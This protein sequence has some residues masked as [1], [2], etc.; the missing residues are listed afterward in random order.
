MTCPRSSKITLTTGQ[1][2]AVPNTP[3]PTHSMGNVLECT[4]DPLSEIMDDATPTPF[5]TI[6]STT[7]FSESVLWNLQRDFYQ[8]VGERAW[9]E[10]I[11]PHFVSNNAF[12][13]KS[14]A[15]IIL[16]FLNDWFDDQNPNATDTEPVYVI[17]F[18]AGI[19]KLGY[20]VLQELLASRDFFPERCGDRVPFT[21]VLSDCSQKTIDYWSKHP[22]LQ[23][24]FELGVLDTA[25]IDVSVPGLGGEIRLHRS[26]VVISPGNPTSNPIFGICN[27]VFNSLKT[28]T[29]QIHKDGRLYVGA[30]SVRTSTPEPLPQ[31]DD[32]H[33]DDSKE[34]Q[35]GNQYQPLRAHEIIQGLDCDWS[36]AFVPKNNN[37]V[38]YGTNDLLNAIPRTY[39][40]LTKAYKMS[41]SATAASL[42]QFTASFTMPIGG[43]NLLQILSRMSTGKRIVMMVGDKGY[44]KMSEMR[45]PL[46]NPHIARHGSFSTM[47]N[48]HSL[49]LFV[50]ELTGLDATGGAVQQQQGTSSKVAT[51]K[52][53]IRIS[54]YGEGF[55]NCL[56]GLGF[57][58]TEVPNTLWSFEEQTSS[59]GTDQISSLQRA[60]SEQSRNA[61]LERALGLLRLCHYDADV[62][63]KFK[64]I[65]IKAVGDVETSSMVRKDLTVM[66][67]LVLSKYYHIR[68]AKD[69]WFELGRINMG[70]GKVVCWWFGVFGVVWWCWWFGGLLTFFC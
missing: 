40:T 14:Y 41:N 36:Y 68:I 39:Q 6:Q 31:E 30:V 1:A 21:Y 19:G 55:K 52:A 63:M 56:I 70:L 7:R 67:K 29:Y 22:Q 25:L 46:K 9:T 15:T 11:V 48:F 50:D 18:G 69:I 49:Q 62:F 5:R 2:V 65:F 16:E 27:Y 66:T 58:K 60:E 13:A 53:F 38:L 33:H 10:G 45:G 57:D 12:I 47:V 35:G 34:T 37:N 51:E 3:A 28:D 4:A 43:I 17:E 64:N 24:L 26:G 61:T 44:T 23:P 54:P 42:D 20:L 8:H 32:G 59:H